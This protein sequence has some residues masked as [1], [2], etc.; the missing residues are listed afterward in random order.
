M[1]RILE[2]LLLANIKGS[3]MILNIK[4]YLAFLEIFFA[5]LSFKTTYNYQ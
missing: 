5:P 4:K 1:D 3:Y 2:N